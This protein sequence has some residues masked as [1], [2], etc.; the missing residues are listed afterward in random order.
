MFSGKSPQVLHM[1]FTHDLRSNCVCFFRTVFRGNPE[2]IAD[3]AGAKKGE[4]KAV[5]GRVWKSA[6]GAVMPLFG[7]PAGGGQRPAGKKVH[8]A[9]GGG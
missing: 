8:K 3:A 7:G 5:T 6:F 9:M 1:I 2:E 4:K